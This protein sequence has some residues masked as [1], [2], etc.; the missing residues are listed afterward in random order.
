[1]YSLNVPVPSQVARRAGDLARQLPQARPRPRGEHT[2]VAKRL[3]TGDAPDYHRIEARGR[4]VLS[5]TPAFEARVTGIEQFA[6]AVT[7]PSPVVYFAVESP[8]LVRLHDRLC[9][10]FDPVDGIEGD[11]Y[12][13]HVTIARGGSPERAREMC[14]RAF[15]PIEWTVTALE[16]RDA[17]RGQPVSTVSLP[18]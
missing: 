15:D 3:G 16:F 12:V 5:G 13:P 9:E 4:E 14:E 17:E 8:G 11:G 1:M 10:A 6:D 2:L 18:A 7:G